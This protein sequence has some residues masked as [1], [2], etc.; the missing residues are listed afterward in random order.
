MAGAYAET[1]HEIVDYQIYCLDPEVKDRQTNTELLLRGPKPQSL[2]EGKYFVCIGG[3]QTFGRFC[4]KP[5][6]VLLQE[7]L[8]IPAIN[9]GRG[10]AGPSFFSKDNNKLLTYINRAKFAIIQIM[11]GRSESN[12]LFHSSGLGAYTRVSDGTWIGCDEAFGELIEK[13]EEDYVRKI[14]AE[15]RYNWV[16]NSIDLLEMIKIPKVLFWFSVRKPHY[17]E[18]YKDVQSLFGEFPQLV[19][20]DMVR[21]LI[22]HSDGYIEWVSKRGLPHLLKSRFTNKPTLIEDPWG[23][24]WSE[25]WYYPSPEMH[26]DAANALEK[27]CKGYL[28]GG[29][30]NQPSRLSFIFGKRWFKREQ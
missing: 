7:K 14:V 24:T 3:A 18:K 19:N 20:S 13:E 10:G 2:E 4:E 16:K 25:N 15:T 22:P 17:I 30:Y 8:G 11:A 12:S 21:Q 27:V 28:N 23:G 6:P 1:D 26:S 9:L 5:Y 29:D